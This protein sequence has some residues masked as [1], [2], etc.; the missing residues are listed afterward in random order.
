VIPKEIYKHTQTG[1]F[2]II[3]IVIVL[4]ICLGIFYSSWI[5]ILVSGVLL[6]C[7]ILFPNLTVIVDDDFVQI[8][9]GLGLIRKKFKLEDIK[10]CAVVRNKLWYGWGIHWFPNGLLFNI[11]GLDAVELLMNNGKIYRIGTDEPQK[12]NEFIQKKLFKEK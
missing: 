10:S 4:A 5:S 9:F 3:S 7:I 8:R 12:L 11:S 2:I 6:I 1:W